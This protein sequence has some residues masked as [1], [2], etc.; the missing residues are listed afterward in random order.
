MKNVSRKAAK[1]APKLKVIAGQVAS[2]KAVALRIAKKLAH[3]KELG[4]LSPLQ[5]EA[6]IFKYRI[7]ARKLGRSIL[8]RRG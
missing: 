8:R 3:S 7:K 2:K 1:K 4:E 6:L 5:Q